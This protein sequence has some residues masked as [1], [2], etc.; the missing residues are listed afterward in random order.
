[1]IL[2]TTSPTI[3]TPESNAKLTT[4]LIIPN[5]TIEK[6]NQTKPNLISA[7]EQTLN[8]KHTEVSMK[9][10]SKPVERS[11]SSRQLTEESVVETS[12]AGLTEEDANTLKSE[13][14]TE[15]F[16]ITLNKNI[17]MDTE[18]KELLVSTIAAPKVEVELG[19][20][21]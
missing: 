10:I 2:E 16:K 1:M 11:T 18:I 17:F 6:F 12:V 14:E 15:D 21:I 4:K 9:L 5:I 7:F 20:L 13:M 8:V 19:K 3:T